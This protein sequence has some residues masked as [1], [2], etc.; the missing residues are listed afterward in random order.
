M[1][2]WGDGSIVRLISVQVLHTTLLPQNL[3]HRYYG[4]CAG[5]SPRAFRFRRPFLVTLLD[6]QKSNDIQAKSAIA[7]VKLGTGVTPTIES[8]PSILGKLPISS[9]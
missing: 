3:T 9:S 8:H 4:M 6:E 2:G 5:C 1:A 7:S